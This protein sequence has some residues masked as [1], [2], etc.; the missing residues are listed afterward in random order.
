MGTKSI[1]NLEISAGLGFG[2]LAGRNSF[3]NPLGA[4]S[5]RFSERD[6]IKVGRG[7][8]LGSVNWFQGKVSP[9]YGIQYRLGKKIEFSLEYSSDLMS[10]ESLYMDIKSPWNL[11][12][13]IN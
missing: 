6:E 2:R 8:T 11:V 1:G 10:N 5:S 4:F 13:H 9:F 3:S 12:R 7:G